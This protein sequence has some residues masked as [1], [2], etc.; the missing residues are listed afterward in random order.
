VTQFFFS[1][2]SEGI[3]EY[4]GEDV[5][6]LNVNWYRDQIGYVGQ[7]PTLFNETIANNISY[8]APE[9]SR[10]EIVEAAKAANAYDF[11][12]SFPEGFDTPVG[13]RGTQ[14]SGGQK[15]RIA[16]STMV[17]SSQINRQYDSIRNCSVSPDRTCLGEET[18]SPAS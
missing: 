7:E 18:R 2:P 4:L 15:Q 16:V 17:M 14:L 10:D 6:N 12:M 13:E 8:G 9:A 1:D 5:K 11:I 3:L